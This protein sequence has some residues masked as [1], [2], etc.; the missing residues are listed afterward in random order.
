MRSNGFQVLSSTTC[1]PQ[2]YSTM[3]PDGFQV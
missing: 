2:P 3:K 1:P